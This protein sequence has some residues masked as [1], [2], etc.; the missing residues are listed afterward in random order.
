MHPA[1]LLVDQ[2]VDMCHQAGIANRATDFVGRA[3]A[4]TDEI[5]RIARHVVAGVRSAD[6]LVER[7]VAI[8]TADVDRVAAEKI[9]NLL[10]ALCGDLQPCDNVRWRRVVDPLRSG[11][12]GAD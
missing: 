9:A 2:L 8:A 3:E 5:Y 10:H 12:R 4:G 1:E 11:F 6:R 7:R